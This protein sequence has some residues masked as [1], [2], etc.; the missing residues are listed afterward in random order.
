MGVAQKV[1]ERAL[2]NLSPYYVPLW[3][4]SA[5]MRNMDFIPTPP[6][7]D[8]P[9]AHQLFDQVERRVGWNV[10]WAQRNGDAQGTV[11]TTHPAPPAKRGGQRFGVKEQATHRA[12]QFFV[13]SER[14]PPTE[15]MDALKNTLD[16]LR[17]RFVSA[18]TTTPSR[19]SNFPVRWLRRLEEWCRRV[20]VKKA[21]KSGGLVVMSHQLYTSLVMAHL[22]DADTYRLRE[23]TSEQQAVQE[24]CEIV[25]DFV[26][27]NLDPMDDDRRATASP[28]AS[29][30]WSFFTHA[31]DES[32][33]RIA[34]FYCLPK[35]HKVPLKGRPIAGAPAWPT[36]AMSKWLA[37]RLRIHTQRY[38]TVLAGTKSL[39]QCLDQTTLNELDD[40]LLIT[41]DVVAMY[42]SIKHDVAKLAVRSELRE[43]TP[44]L[45]AQEINLAMAILDIVL[46]NT[47]VEFD[48]KVY[49][50]LDGLP[51]GSPSS[52]EIANLVLAR[53]EHAFINQLSATDR[54]KLKLWKRFIDDGLIVMQRTTASQ[55]NDLR[56]QYVEHVRQATGLK[57]TF[58]TS[59]TGVVFMDTYISAPPRR[60]TLHTRLHIKPSYMNQ[61]IPASSFH[62]ADN[63]RGWIRGETLRLVLVHSDED[64]FRTALQ[65]FMA[66]LVARG[67]SV[68]FI[69]SAMCN[70]HWARRQEYLWSSG[71][72]PGTGGVLAVTLPHTPATHAGLNALRSVRRE[73]EELVQSSGARVTLAR[74]VGK[75]IGQLVT[76]STYR[77]PHSSNPSRTQP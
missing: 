29:I 2:V 32:K 5:L 6:D 21:D 46:C 15:T 51:M 12:K 27:A 4:R 31:A 54:G 36:N 47:H 70:V 75:K 61:Y 37:D 69:K 53:A 41:L 26:R 45:S 73:T 76:S 58:E 49:H 10:F 55:W 44:W 7:I 71:G 1:H 56:A 22:N 68:R 40:T 9:A 24:V 59:R 20:V 38:N 16:A 66:F 72:G 25:R 33:A 23:N 77:A 8:E 11:R 3:V 30:P 14:K 50:Q 39:L 42:P 18:T 28:W 57:L 65:N 62:P 19:R 74:T 13:P 67:Y 60:K 64:G 52:P 34:R 63:K 17:R 48:G 43:V 35:L